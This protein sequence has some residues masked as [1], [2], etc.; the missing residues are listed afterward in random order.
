MF[1]EPSFVFEYYIA[2]K[3]ALQSSF[4]RID[5]Q[6]YVTRAGLRLGLK[7]DGITGLRVNCSKM[8]G[9]RVFGSKS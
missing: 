3:G 5:R 8:L 6:Q 4:T 7:V 1:G 2:L 9:E